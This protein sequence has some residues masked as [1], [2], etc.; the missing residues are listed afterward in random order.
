LGQTKLPKNGG[1]YW[2]TSRR[3]L[4]VPQNRSRALKTKFPCKNLEFLSL[5][6]LLRGLQFAREVLHWSVI[7]KQKKWQGDCFWGKG[8]GVFYPPT[9]N[10]KGEGVFYPPT[11]NKKRLCLWDMSVN[12]SPPASGCSS[13]T[14][15]DLFSCP[16]THHID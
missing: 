2:R 7:E 6:R 5:D 10:G 9:S 8:E 12:A 14:K 11:L 13:T 3:N 15:Y 1:K 4:R 16:H